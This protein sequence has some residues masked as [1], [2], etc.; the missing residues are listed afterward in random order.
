MAEENDA[1]MK[2]L[3]VFSAQIPGSRGFWRH[4]QKK[5]FAFER[6]LEWTSQGQDRLNVFITLSMPD[7]HLQELHRLLP[8]HEAYLY[9]TVVKRKEDIPAGEDPNN[10]I[11]EAEDYRL[12]CKALAD[13]GHIVNYFAEYRLKTFIEEVLQKGLGVVDYSVR[14]EFQ[15]R[16]AVHYHLV[17]HM[18]SNVSAEEMEEAF[19]EYV[20]LD[21][22]DP[23]LPETEKQEEIKKAKRRGKV[24]VEEGCKTE[25]EAR[26][27]DL[28]RRVCDFAVLDFG[29]SAVHPNSDH[30]KWP[31]NGYPAPNVNVVR[32]PYP[33][34]D[35]NNMELDH[36]Y[37]KNRVERHQH[38]ASYCLRWDS[39]TGQSYCRFGFPKVLLGYRYEEAEDGTKKLVR[40]VNDFPH[41]ASAC[42]YGIS[43]L[44]NHEYMVEHVPEL[45]QIWRGKWP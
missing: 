43:Y 39:R 4:A 33:G 16:T 22:L 5:L 37:L 21:D 31:E 44:R 38:S 9:K 29:I 36:E 11:T 42:E 35:A 34:H 20:Y 14:V 25:T 28:R 41:G 8:G 19:K 40:V 26:V 27:E 1:I 7:H 17:G 13:N 45:L 24:V 12:R 3:T 6:W 30:T 32:Y 2:S 10:Y 18:L 23:E 15:S